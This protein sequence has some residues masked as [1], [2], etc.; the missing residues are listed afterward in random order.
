MQPAERGPGCRQACGTA[1]SRS[2]SLPS[3]CPLRCPARCVLPACPPRSTCTCTC[4]PPADRGIV[5]L[6]QA[7]RRSAGQTGGERLAVPTKDRQRRV[8]PRCDPAAAKAAAGPIK[9]SRDIARTKL[10]GLQGSPNCEAWSLIQER[11]NVKKSDKQSH[12]WNAARLL[13]FVQAAL[14][15][16]RTVPCAAISDQNKK[17]KQSICNE[18]PFR[19]C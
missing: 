16:F 11:K 14:K 10:R 2:I 17:H 1:T 13:A 15:S 3:C 9:W 7:L 18:Q 19:P 12:R 5:W 6:A 4:S 8:C